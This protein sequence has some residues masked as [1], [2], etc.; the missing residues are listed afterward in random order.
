MC[1]ARWLIMNKEVY[2]T[3]AGCENKFSKEEAKSKKLSKDLNAMGLEKAQL[4]SDKRALEFKLDMVVDKEA[5]TKAK[6]EIELKATKEYHA[7]AAETAVAIANSNLEA[8]IVEKDKQLAEAREE[9]EK[10]EVERAD[11]VERVVLAYKEEFENTPEYMELAHRFITVGGE[12]LVER[13]G[14]THPE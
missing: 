7:F 14:K 3:V 8:V 1:L 12:Q 2:N 6:Y 4:E 13:I 10:V 11:A 9:V 5:D